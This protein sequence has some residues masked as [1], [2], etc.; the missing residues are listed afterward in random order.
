LAKMLKQLRGGM[1]LAQE[2]APE[3]G[4]MATIVNRRENG[5]AERQR[6]VASMG[7]ALRE[8]DGLK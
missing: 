4:V 5:R 8:E 1:G 6:V 7:K 3:V 2:R